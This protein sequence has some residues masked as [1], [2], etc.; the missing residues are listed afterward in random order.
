MRLL[1]LQNSGQLTLAEYFQDD[2]PS[3]AIL[4]HSWG[5]DDQEITFQEIK[6]GNQRNY[7][8]KAGFQKIKLCGEQAARDGIQYFWVD[9]CCI[10]KMDSNELSEAVNSMFRWYQNSSVCYVY[11]A[12]ISSQDII[13]RY[14]YSANETQVL[15]A[16]V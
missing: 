3:Y 14:S 15:G 12:D 2:I 10:N 5:P 7:K 1:Q 13:T 11:L 16:I 9:T 4:S 6:E 8:R